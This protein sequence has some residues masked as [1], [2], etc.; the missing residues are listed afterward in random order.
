MKTLDRHIAEV[1][2]SV[3]CVSGLC[4]HCLRLTTATNS[5]F[6][7]RH[8]IYS[9]PCINQLD[10]SR[11]TRSILTKKEGH[12]QFLTSYR[13]LVF[14]PVVCQKQYPIYFVLEV[15]SVIIFFPQFIFSV[16][17]LISRDELWIFR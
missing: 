10:C 8:P 9:R 6:S 7:C 11:S 14:D 17:H 15:E 12:W 3:R 2:L 4:L 5:K 16:F 13:I 1:M